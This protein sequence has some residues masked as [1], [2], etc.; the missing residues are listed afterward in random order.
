MTDIH[1]HIL[2]GIDDGA[3]CIEEA[4]DMA[5]LA[6]E[7]GV[8]DIICTSHIRCNHDNPKTV[9][10]KIENLYKELRNKLEENSIPVNL[11]MGAEILC[12]PDIL[13]YLE[14]RLLPTLGGTD[15]LLAEFPF[16]AP[17]EYINSML[18]KTT[19]MNYRPVIAHPERYSA[20]RRD[21]ALL[22]DWFD[23]G[24]ILQLNKG[25]I[26]GAFGSRVR[27]TALEMLDSGLCHVIASDAHGSIS[28]TP[29]IANLIDFLNDRYK[30]EYIALLL[31][32]NPRRILENRDT[33]SV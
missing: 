28:R 4:L 18:K 23:R 21:P 26:L 13:L 20:V 3:S 15:Y 32:E 5:V 33:V 29:S 31:D 11:Y 25:S 8:T 16:D 14:K 7:S 17:G 10:A 6:A 30:P 9:A 22:P 2:P 24:Y 27:T 19:A 1:C 12:L